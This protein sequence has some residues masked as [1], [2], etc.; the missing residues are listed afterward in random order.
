MLF[1]VL[2]ML[3]GGCG[4]EGFRLPETS[5]IVPEDIA[6]AAP[7]SMGSAVIQLYYFNM[8]RPRP[9]S[10]DLY[11]VHRAQITHLTAQ[12]QRWSAK[13]MRLHGYPGIE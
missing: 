4:E 9:V 10:P 5:P 7:G 2:L 3:G 11:A 6:P 1:I 13:Q 8:Q 12:A